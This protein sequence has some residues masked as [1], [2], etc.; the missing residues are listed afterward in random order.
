LKI[1][2][3]CIR[4]RYA[5][6]TGS[7]WGKF[8]LAIAFAISLIAP[9]GAVNAAAEEYLAYVGVAASQRAG[10]W[11]YGESHVLRYREGRLAERVVLY[12]C[13][14]GTPFARKHAQYDEALAPSFLFEDSSNGVREGVRSSERAGGGRTGSNRTVFYRGVDGKE[15][16]APLPAVPGLVID[17]GFDEFIRG[18]WH[19]LIASGSLPLQFLVP[20]RLE[21]LSFQVQHVRSGAKDGVATE[22]FRLKLQGIVGWIAPS[23]DVSYSEREHVLLR[24]E[25]LSDLR[26][27]AGENLR[28]DISFRSS[29]RK[30]SDAAAVAD[31]IR[32]PLAACR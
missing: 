3:N 12:T 11:L 8:C 28:T 9:F 29:D 18:N 22:V 4:F 20:S 27:K 1:L 24:Y 10:Q 13:R 32:A 26:D 31:A 7:V 19:A 2:R 25:G 14:D 17:S 15:R 16:T 23:I 30:P 21:T 5:A 6:E